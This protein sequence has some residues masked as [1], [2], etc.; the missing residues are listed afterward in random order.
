MKKIF[1]VFKLDSDGKE[2][3]RMSYLANNSLE[4][5]EMN[6]YYLALSNGKI[7]NKEI[8]KTQNGHEMQYLST[9]YWCQD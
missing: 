9:T 7:S 5:M 3:R 2:Q 4:A 6:R 1:N 8:F